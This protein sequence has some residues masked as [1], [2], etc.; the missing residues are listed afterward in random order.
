MEYPYALNVV[1][2]AFA[3][4]GQSSRPSVVDDEQENPT[5]RDCSMLYEGIRKAILACHPW[6]FARCIQ[7][8]NSASANNGQYLTVVPGDCVRV[9]KLLDARG[10][11]L[12]RT[13]SGNYLYSETPATTLVYIRDEEDPACWD[14]WARKALV[15]RLAADFSRIVKGSLQERQ[16]QEDA[17]NLALA[18]AKRLNSQEEY[19]NTKPSYAEDLLTGRVR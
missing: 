5:F 13:R 1:R 11:E 17:Y 8:V 4:L 6:N 7:P 3:I 14:E 19:V 18:E 16:L 12:E 10:E 9:L 15:H 2:Q